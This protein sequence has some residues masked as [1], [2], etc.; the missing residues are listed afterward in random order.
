MAP[1]GGNGSGR[2]GFYQTVTDAIRDFTLHGY[3]A[4]WRL[5]MWVERIRAAAIASLTP[6]EVLEK[7]LR[8]AL[9]TVYSRMVDKGAILKYH[10][11]VSAFTINRVKPKL[12]AAVDRSILASAGLIRLN[13]K[14]AVEQTVQRFVGWSSS[15]PAGGSR[16]VDKVDTK[17]DIRKSLTQLPW[18]ERRVAI[19]QGHKLVASLS[20]IIAVDGGAIGAIWK[21]HFRQAGYKFRKDHAERDGKF[22]AVR[23]CWAIEKG[24]MKVGPAGYL[25]EMTQ[26]GEEVFCRCFVQWVYAIRKLP[27]DMLTALGKTELQRLKVAA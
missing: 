19:D 17:D 6:P 9:T 23:G 2:A 24:L 16:V 11:D 27:Q 1:D 12:R 15:I 22:Y 25:D 21:S 8:D 18:E 20:N 13:Q 7:G 10:P 3:D 14:Q 4:Q 26:P 5:D